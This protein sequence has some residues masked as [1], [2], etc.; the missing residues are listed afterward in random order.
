MRNYLLLARKIFH[1]AN[2][3][4]MLKNRFIYQSVLCIVL[5]CRKHSKILN[6]SIQ[7]THY[8]NNVW[9][10]FRCD[11]WIMLILIFQTEFGLDLQVSKKILSHHGIPK[12]DAQERHPSSHS[13]SSSTSSKT[14]R[15]FSGYF[16]L[17][18]EL[19]EF[20]GNKKFCRILSDLA[21]VNKNY[22][23]EFSY[24]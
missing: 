19:F 12:L 14:Q 17:S 13:S 22:F 23:L 16:V 11:I 24:C 2:L 5:I 9:Y 6:T 7:G 1:C 3:A 15:C 4:S 10:F 18:S 8:Q 20:F 21:D